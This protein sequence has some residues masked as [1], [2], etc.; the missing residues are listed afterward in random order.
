[1][2]FDVEKDYGETTDVKTEHP[3]VVRDLAAQ[4]DA[5]WNSL[6]GLLVNEHAVGPRINPFKELFWQ[7]FGGGPSDE[8]LRLMGI[9][10]SQPLKGS[11]DGSGLKP[12]TK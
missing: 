7:Q 1:M 11:A 10:P 9:S 5:W 12:D 3:A 2:L 6:D 4:F 8:D